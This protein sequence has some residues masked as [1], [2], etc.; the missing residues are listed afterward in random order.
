MLE[1]LY[2]FR[3]PCPGRARDRIDRRAGTGD[4]RLKLPNAGG[5]RLGRAA[6]VGHTPL[7]LWHVYVLELWMRRERSLAAKVEADPPVACVVN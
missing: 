6:E 4:R 7:Q 2:E 1:A 5:R 3:P